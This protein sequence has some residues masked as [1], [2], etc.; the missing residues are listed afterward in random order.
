MNMGVG[1]VLFVGSTLTGLVW[2]LP[3]HARHMPAGRALQPYRLE[4][5]NTVRNPTVFP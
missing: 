1:G 2:D 4:A 3:R 5:G